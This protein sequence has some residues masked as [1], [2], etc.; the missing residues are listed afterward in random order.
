MGVSFALVVVLA[1]FLET[2]GGDGTCRT[3][4]GMQVRFFES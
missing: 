2:L 3:F 1:S 4:D